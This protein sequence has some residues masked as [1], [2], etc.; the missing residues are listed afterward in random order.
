M[1]LKFQLAFTVFTKNRIIKRITKLIFLRIFK[2][3]VLTSQ[4]SQINKLDYRLSSKCL[5][6]RNEFKKSSTLLFNNKIYMQ[7]WNSSKVYTTKHVSEYIS[8][9]S[10]I[11]IKLLIWKVS[12]VSI[13]VC[14]HEKVWSMELFYNK[15]YF[16]VSMF[17]LII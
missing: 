9:N 4:N 3:E 6:E 14:N 16:S 17:V 15:S 12:Y 5:F 7:L 8:S 2:K 13:F 1:F 10:V 11:Y